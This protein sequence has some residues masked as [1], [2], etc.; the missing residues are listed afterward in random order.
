MA[1]E[2]LSQ[3]CVLSGIAWIALIVAADETFYNRRVPQRN[4]PGRGNKLARLFG[5]GR[6]KNRT[7]W[8]LKQSAIRTFATLCKPTIFL[9]SMAYVF[10]F[11]W[12]VG[13]V[14]PSLLL[15]SPLADPL[16][17]QNTTLT[18]FLTPPPP[19]G[20]GFGP[21]N[22]AV[23]YLTPIVGSI[24]GELQGHFAND[25]FANWYIRRHHGH[26]EPEIRLL[27]Y[28]TGVPT[29]IVGLNILGLALEKHLHYMWASF[30]WFLYAHGSRSPFPSLFATMTRR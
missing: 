5:F 23:F 9:T 20:Y 30:G 18:L 1:D 25:F 11:A 15:S 19:Q 22:I 27:G 29:M 4:Q 12:G 7:R 21:G 16:D 6:P 3:F 26:F 14:S 8:T 17:G 28:L 24:L 2:R 10:S 13:I